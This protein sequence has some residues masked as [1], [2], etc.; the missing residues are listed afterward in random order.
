MIN[1]IP[2]YEY[3]GNSLELINSNFQELNIDICNMSYSANSFW[4][5]FFDQY[6]QIKNELDN[7]YNVVAAA[8]ASWRSASDMITNLKKYWL[9]PINIV[10]PESFDVIVDVET[11]TNWANRNISP[12]SFYEDQ[13]LRVECLTRNYNKTQLEDSR[14]YPL[15][16]TSQI[17]N[18]SALNIDQIQ[19]IQ[20]ALATKYNTNVDDASYFFSYKNQIELFIE[21]DVLFD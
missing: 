21:L 13:L 16:N 6:N 18:P 12:Q 20:D 15:L 8:S 5:P 2:S 19:G 9:Q 3:L 10:Y 11:V 1:T 4:N 17:L 7:T 14:Y